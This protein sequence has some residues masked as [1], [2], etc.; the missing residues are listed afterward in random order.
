MGVACAIGLF[1]TLSSVA[2]VPTHVWDAVPGDLV[3]AVI[4][5]AAAATAAQ[6]HID[7]YGDRDVKT[8]PLILHAAT[9]TTYPISFVEAQWA[10]LEF[11]QYNPPPFRL[12]GGG[13]FKVPLTY[14]PDEA[15]VERAK[16]WT[17]W[18]VSNT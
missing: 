7:G 4:L 1:S 3:S 11:I 13:L 15:A 18:K 9:S 2:M 6:V 8:A 14:K 10:S 17:A 5:A 12:P 16:A